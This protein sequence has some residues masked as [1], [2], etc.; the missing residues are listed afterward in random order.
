MPADGAD[1]GVDTPV[2][3]RDVDL[4]PGTDSGPRERWRL[5]GTNSAG[6]DF[7]DVG[8]AVGAAVVVVVVVVVVVGDREDHQRSESAVDVDVDVDVDA[9]APGL[10][11][12]VVAAA[13]AVAFVAGAVQSSWPGKS[14]WPGPSIAGSEGTPGSLREDQSLL[15]VPIEGLS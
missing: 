10:F 7:V 2:E 14:H 3:A 5:R 11:D 13:D 15:Q 12:V 4:G 9:V 1:V 6:D 8:G